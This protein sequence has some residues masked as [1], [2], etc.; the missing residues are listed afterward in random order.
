MVEILCDFR[1]VIIEIQ[2][3]ISSIIACLFVF[4]QVF[5]YNF[6]FLISS[7]KVNFC[8]VWQSTLRYDYGFCKGRGNCKA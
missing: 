2:R 1:S 6:Y 3:S 8:V 4:L 7:Y 5:D